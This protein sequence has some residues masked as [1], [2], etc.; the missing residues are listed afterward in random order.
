MSTTK[1]PPAAVITAGLAI[2]MN[3]EPAAAILDRVLPNKPAR[4]MPPGFSASRFHTDRGRYCPVKSTSHIS[5]TTSQ[6]PPTL[7]R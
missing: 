4:E 1:L 2:H 5:A 6:G 3:T 7:C